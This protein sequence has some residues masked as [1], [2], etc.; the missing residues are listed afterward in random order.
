MLGMDHASDPQPISLDASEWK[1]ARDF[2]A[3]VFQAIKAPDW[4]G[5]SPD[6]LVDSMIWG[7]EINGW[8][9]PYKIV[10]N[11]LAETLLRVHIELCSRA[12][13]GS[14]EEFKQRHGYDVDVTLAL[15]D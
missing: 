4:H 6:A 3:A 7:G 1:D 15:S 11:H 14:R 8:K 13:Q 2:Y 10:V 9:P 5:M 12:L